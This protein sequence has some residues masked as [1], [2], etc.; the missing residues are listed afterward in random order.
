MKIISIYILLIISILTTACGNKSDKK[1]EIIPPKNNRSYES[2]CYQKADTDFINKHFISTEIATVTHLYMEFSELEA[3]QNLTS[4]RIAEVEKS[5]I[6]LKPGSNTLSFETAW[7]FG[8]RAQW[9]HQDKNNLLT[10]FFN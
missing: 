7:A 2:A 8:P 3:C 4:L 1:D 10:I 9:H 6:N 5:D